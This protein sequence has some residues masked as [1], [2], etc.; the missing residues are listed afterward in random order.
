MNDKISFTYNKEKREMPL[1]QL[2]EFVKN[3]NN[4]KLTEK[5][6]REFR[7]AIEVLTKN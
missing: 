2:E 4:G 3:N 6:L 5:D 1:S 7:E